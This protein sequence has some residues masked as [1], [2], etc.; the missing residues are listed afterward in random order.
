MKYSIYFTGHYRETNDGRTDVPWVI[1]NVIAGASTGT[2]RR[3]R[4][5]GGREESEEGGVV[6]SGRLGKVNRNRKP[7][8]K[9]NSLRVLK[10]GNEKFI[11]VWFENL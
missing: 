6:K 3:L 10:R 9:E 8:S 4:G 5:K 1:S 11:K 2:F 7:Y